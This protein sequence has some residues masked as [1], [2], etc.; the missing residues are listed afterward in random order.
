MVQNGE[1]FWSAVYAPFMSRD[2]TR[3]DVRKIV[4]EGLL[5]TRGGYKAVAVL[6]NVPDDHRRLLSFLRK[7]NCHL[8]EHDL[9]QAPADLDQGRARRAIGQ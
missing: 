7:H 1:S 4:K 3:D 2:L 8:P 9:R 6:F 5:R